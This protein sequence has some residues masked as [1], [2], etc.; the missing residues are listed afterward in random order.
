MF[1]CTAAPHSCLL[2][3]KPEVYQ[4]E[5]EELERELQELKLKEIQGHMPSVNKTVWCGSRQA[6]SD[7]QL[8]EMAALH[9][10]SLL[11]V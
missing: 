4:N 6:T 9:A 11:V 8:F 1:A 10:W 7:P 3:F 5:E 2:Q